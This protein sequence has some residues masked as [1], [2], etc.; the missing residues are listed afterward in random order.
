MKPCRAPGGED[1]VRTLSV[2]PV[3]GLRRRE[4]RNVDRALASSYVQD[5][6]QNLGESTKTS[7]A[8]LLVVIT[9]CTTPSPAD[10]TTAAPAAGASI[11]YES[12]GATESQTRPGPDMT[13]VIAVSRESIFDPMVASTAHCSSVPSASNRTEPQRVLATATGAPK[14]VAVC[15]CVGDTEA[16][17]EGLEEALPEMDCVEA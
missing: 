11:V 7:P 14:G 15:V 2:S 16:E 8:S 9:Y 17:T 4:N 12:A 3:S 10:P 6:F 1:R 5:W 13:N